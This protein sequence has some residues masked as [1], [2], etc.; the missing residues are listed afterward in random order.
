MA[1]KEA[2]LQVLLD[3]L[4]KWCV[5]WRMFVNV[6]KIAIMHFLPKRRQC[7]NVRFMYEGNAVKIVDKYK[8]IGIWFMEHVE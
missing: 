8:Y 5:R 6:D 2:D 3:V 7:T 4:Q 1:E